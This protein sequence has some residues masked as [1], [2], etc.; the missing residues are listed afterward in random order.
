[1]D[2]QEAV[3]GL[4]A[5]GL[6]E[7]AVGVQRAGYRARTRTG[8]AS[9]WESGISRAVVLCAS[10]RGKGRLSWWRGGQG[11]E[12]TSDG[13]GAGWGEGEGGWGRGNGRERGSRGADLG[14]SDNV[15]RG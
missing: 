5:K 11:L 2:A 1:M 9:G 4:R 12:P 8:A 3:G 6:H 13:R 10:D 7:A 15:D 14:E